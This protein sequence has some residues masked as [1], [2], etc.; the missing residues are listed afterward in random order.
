MD[1]FQKFYNDIGRK[2]PE[3]AIVYKTLRG[4]LRKRFILERCREWQGNILEIG[5]NAGTYLLS[6]SSR[7]KLGVDIA[8]SLL[9]GIRSKDASIPLSAMDAHSL[10]IKD[11][12][13]DYVLCSEVLEHLD[14]PEKAF[15]EIA[16]VLRPGGT[17]F[18]T[19]PNYRGERPTWV[20]IGA[21]AEHG[22]ADVRDGLYFHTAF[23]PSEL[24][25]FGYKSGLETIESGTLEK[26]V[27]YAAK[28]PAVI[29]ILIRF[30]NRFTLKLKSVDIFNEK[31]FNKL[32]VI[33]Y[34]LA[35][36]TGLHFLLMPFIKEGVRSYIFLRKKA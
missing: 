35:R 17:A 12:Q 30:F 10:A 29:L 2:Y 33:I 4:I 20:P 11:N 3:E 19:T 21:L 28:I 36:V 5:C 24:E 13:F 14:S 9:M 8:E 6:F 26:E 1:T 23:R 31:L 16:R 32:Q 18:L 7:Q 22:I 15:Q 25:E 34:R 27:R